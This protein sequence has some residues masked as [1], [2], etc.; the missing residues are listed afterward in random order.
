MLHLSFSSGRELRL[1][2][3][4]A[5]GTFGREG[6]NPRPELGVMPENRLPPEFVARYGQTLDRLNGV[7]GRMDAVR[8]SPEGIALMREGRYG[9]YPDGIRPS[10][11]VMRETNLVSPYLSS[12]PSNR[13]PWTFV[14]SSWRR[15][16]PTFI[17]GVGMGMAP[18]G[19]PP[20]YRPMLYTSV[21]YPLPN[22]PYRLPMAGPRPYLRPSDPLLWDQR[23]AYNPIPR[24]PFVGEPPPDPR[25]SPLARVPAP[26]AAPAQ[27][28]AY[29]ASNVTIGAPARPVTLPASI[30][31]ALPRPADIDFTYDGPAQAI[32]LAVDDGRSVAVNTLPADGQS[33]RYDAGFT[34]TRQG[35]RYRVVF[36]QN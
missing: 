12:S 30:E 2:A 9:R 31:A 16:Q 32:T 15:S 3:Q 19:V 21:P 33:L 24:P 6:P 26:V 22:T 29:A 28:F 34:I 1:I 4:R 36:G 23:T 25:R 11:P 18:Y 17:P 35:N 13:L 7:I 5:I 27:P 14:P 10:W 8:V 20:A